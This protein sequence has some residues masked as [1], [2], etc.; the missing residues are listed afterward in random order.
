ML[1]HERRLHAFVEHG[2]FC[3]FV[4]DA[5]GHYLYI[6]P[7]MERAAG[8]SL[9]ALRGSGD[10]ASL[11]L[12]LAALAR[13]HDSR[14]ERG[15]TVVS[16]EA[17]PQPD[18]TTRHWMVVSFPF[19]PPEGGRAIGGL[20]L[21]VS[22]RQSRQLQLA[23]SE[24]LYRHL[25]ES[26]QG[27]ICTHDM[28][29]WLLTVNQAA[30]ASIGLS[31]QELVG[32]NLRDLLTEE[33]RALFA[34]YLDRMSRE[35]TA[36][37][38]MFVRASNGR[39]LAWKYHNVTVREPGKPPY[40]LGHAQDV[41]ELR[42]AQERLTHLAMTDDLT[43]LQNRRGFFSAGARSLAE[44]HRQRKAMAAIYVDI[45]GLK[46]VN[47]AFG[48][49][50]GTT[51]ILGAA[52]VLKNSFRAADVLARVGGDEFVALA[53]VS[54]ADADRIMTRLKWHLDKF[55]AGAGLP[56]QLALSIGIA[57]MEPESSKSLGELVGEADAVM[58]ERKRRRGASR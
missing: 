28:D 44:A 10:L 9:A 15:E 42:E 5:Q 43:G 34:R 58:Y 11:P 22:D 8:V 19:T 6:N 20:A 14:V 18:G 26:A 36:S 31:A 32:T 33:S 56:Y 23:E 40:V 49:D 2:P 7:A 38:M 21:D 27:L 4:K 39:E 3:A 12:L 54:L 24:R 13:D 16:V 35:G 1:D 29:G 51:L 52:D 37:G 53:T 45:D 41:S 17:A 50:A 57:H 48:H 25:V 55:N 30:L 46:R 47:D